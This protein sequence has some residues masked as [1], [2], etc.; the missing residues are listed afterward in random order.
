M[1]LSVL[2]E[3]CSCCHDEMVCSITNTHLASLIWMGLTAR[4]KDG[5]DRIRMRCRCCQVTA[6][7]TGWEHA[8]QCVGWG[9]LVLSWWDGLLHYQYPPGVFNLDGFNGSGQRR[10]R[11]HQNAVPLLPSDSRS[12]WLGACV[13]V[14][15]LRTA[16]AVMMR[17]SAPLPI[18]T[19]RL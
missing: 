10:S 12:N 5:A 6:G 9:L 15:W 16:R 8:S 13:S 1:R 19:W 18:P 3:D 17:W 11:S 7:V 2:V 4:G 14:C